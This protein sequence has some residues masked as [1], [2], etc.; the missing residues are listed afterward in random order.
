MEIHQLLLFLSPSH[1][2]CHIILSPALRLLCHDVNIS[3]ALS[4]LLLACFSGSRGTEQVVNAACVTHTRRGPTRRT[5][6]WPCRSCV[7]AGH[8]PWERCWRGAE[9]STSSQVLHRLGSSQ[10]PCHG[11]RR[12]CA[13]WGNAGSSSGGWWWCASSPWRRCAAH[14]AWT[15]P[16]GWWRG[17][18]GFD[19]LGT[20]LLVDPP[21][22]I[23][24]I[25]EATLFTKLGSDSFARR[26]FANV[27]V[28]LLATT[29]PP[30][31][32]PS[33]FG[34]CCCCSLG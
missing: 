7:V 31:K 13:H 8:R 10:I 32:T 30:T 19:I 2:S 17:L 1:P 22:Q 26:S 9:S 4:R 6:G 5:S 25:H 28:C 24:V 23:R 3:T 33:L 21:L 20:R 14:R 11:S 27:A 34:T 15:S 18:L 12:H 16:G 29:K